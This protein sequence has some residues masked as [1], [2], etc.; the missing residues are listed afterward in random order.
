[1]ATILFVTH[2]SA[3]DAMVSLDLVYDNDVI[4]KTQLKEIIGLGL[5]VKL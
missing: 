4:Q 2:S 3:Q 1:M 5:T